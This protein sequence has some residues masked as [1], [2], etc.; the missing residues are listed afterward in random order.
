MPHTIGPQLVEERARHKKTWNQSIGTSAGQ[1][2]LFTTLRDATAPANA[3]KRALIGMT[4]KERAQRQF[5]DLACCASRQRNASSIISIAALNGGS[6]LHPIY[7]SSCHTKSVLSSW[8]NELGTKR[9]G[10][11]PKYRNICRAAFTHHDS[12]RCYSF[13]KRRQKSV[14]WYDAQMKSAAPVRGLDALR[15]HVQRGASGPLS[16]GR[17]SLPAQY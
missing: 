10:T 16:L 11:E 5:L 2:S 12:A 6:S 8:K 3:H 1:L 7:R 14:H 9:H 17:A 4:H 13:C 15:K